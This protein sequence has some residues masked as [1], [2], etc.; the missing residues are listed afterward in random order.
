LSSTGRENAAD[1]SEFADA[2]AAELDYNDN[3]CIA[4]QS[5][6]T[7]IRLAMRYGNGQKT[8]FG[9]IFGLKHEGGTFFFFKNKE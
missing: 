2:F 7:N 3:D 1:D 5:L 9:I 6:V 4:I 8:Q